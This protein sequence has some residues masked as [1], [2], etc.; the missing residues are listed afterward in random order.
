MKSDKKVKR[1]TKFI[2]L[3]VLV[4]TIIS[5]SYSYSAFFSIESKSTVQAIST[6]TLNVSAS[7][8]SMAKTE[9]FPTEE[10][11]PTSPE[12]ILNNEEKDCAT[13]T[14]SNNGNIDANFIVSISYDEDNIPPESKDVGLVSFDNLIIGIYEESLDNSGWLNLNPDET[15]EPAYNMKITQFVSSGQDVYPILKSRINKATINE[16]GTEPTTRVL[17]VY[18]WLADTTPATE[19]GKLMYLKLN[20]QSMPVEGQNEQQ[21]QINNE[22]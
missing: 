6:G 15:G 1:N 12:S 16:S 17:K 11:L 21:I 2:I 19:I 20:V 22:G 3:S 9:V 5:L 4:L 10:T 18:V 8:T 14:I 7:A 13:L